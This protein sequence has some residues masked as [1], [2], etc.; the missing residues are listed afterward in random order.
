[1]ISTDQQRSDFYY[2]K[3]QEARLLI[4]QRTEDLFESARRQMDLRIWR[5]PKSMRKLYPVLVKQLHEDM[6]GED[7]AR[8]K[9]IENQQHFLRLAQAYKVR[10]GALAT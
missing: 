4:R 7:L 8:K 6:C 1:M 5:Y 10:A 9:L 3:E 2:R